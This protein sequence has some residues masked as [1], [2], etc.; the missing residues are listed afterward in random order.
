MH[1]SGTGEED[2]EVMQVLTTASHNSASEPKMWGQTPLYEVRPYQLFSF[3]TLSEYQTH[4]QKILGRKVLHS[5]H[6]YESWII[7]R[8]RVDC[9]S[10]WATILTHEL[11]TSLS[12]Y[13]ASD[14]LKTDPRL[15]QL[16]KEPTV[17]PCPEP[18]LLCQ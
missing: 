9:V 15:L 10:C 6:I 8:E 16:P 4:P 17:L 5:K 13:R 18:V 1:R 2:Y 14:R 3:L 7:Q 12:R 11:Q